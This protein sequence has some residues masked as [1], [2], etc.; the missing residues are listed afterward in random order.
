ANQRAEDL[1]REVDRA[2]RGIAEALQRSEADRAALRR[3]EEQLRERGE[4]VVAADE[5]RAHLEH[6]LEEVESRARELQAGLASERLARERADRALADA[7]E[8]AAAKVTLLEHELA[9][10]DT[11]Q[12]RI[13]EQLAA[14]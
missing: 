1:A 12:G 3:A 9:E 14:V 2:R 8:E 13:R 6:A 11:L 10:R 5:R 4:R 7:R